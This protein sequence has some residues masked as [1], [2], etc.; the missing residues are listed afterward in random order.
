MSNAAGGLRELHET[1]IALEEVRE[2]IS[3]GPR[4]IRNAEKRVAKREEEIEELRE[5]LKQSK[6]TADQKSLQ[7][8]THETHIGDLKAKLNAAKTN[9]EFDAFK[10]QIDADEMAKSVLEDEILEVFEKIDQI[11]AEIKEAEQQRDAAKNEVQEVKARIEKEAQPLRARADELE[12]A[13]TTLEKKLPESIAV[14][15][16]RLVSA[17]GADA[18]SPVTNQTCQQCSVRIRTN[19]QVELNMGKYVFCDSCGRLLYAADE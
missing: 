19:T 14:T 11:E 6:V 18:L 7:M 9:K 2:K 3:R 10:S 4:Q 5:R 16:R 13:L 8:K 12:Q 17:H 15:Y 1:H